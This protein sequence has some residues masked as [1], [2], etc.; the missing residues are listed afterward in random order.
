MKKIAV[1]F[2]VF[3][4]ALQLAMPDISFGQE[5]KKAAPA[6]P[7]RPAQPAAP[8]AKS[9]KDMTREEL[10]QGIMQTFARDKKYLAMVG[11]QEAKDEKG[12][13]GYIYTRKDGTKV[14][15]QDLDKETLEFM[16]T[17]LRNEM[18]KADTEKTL[19]QMKE[20]KRIQDL[21]RQQKMLKQTAPTRTTT[22]KPVKLPPKT[23]TRR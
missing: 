3:V 12:A 13:I 15:L 21:N 18:T 19:K 2:S 17:R 23:T 9:I 10:V 1:V 11:V 20:L 16:Y 22:Y 7:A 6:Q 4:L 14:R 8:A 5:A